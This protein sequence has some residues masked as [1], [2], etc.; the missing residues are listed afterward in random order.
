MLNIPTKV[1]LKRE[2]SCRHNSKD[3]SDCWICAE[4]SDE[5]LELFAPSL[6]FQYRTIEIKYNNAKST[7]YKASECLMT[8]VGILACLKVAIIWAM[9]MSASHPLDI[10]NNFDVRSEPVYKRF[11]HPA[12]THPA[13]KPRLFSHHTIWVHNHENVHCAAT[14]SASRDQST[15][16]TG[17][18]ETKIDK[19]M[20]VVEKTRVETTDMSN[21]IINENSVLDTN[22]DELQ[23]QSISPSITIETTR[24]KKRMWNVLQ[25][26]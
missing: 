23:H 26:H 6:N 25:T 12:L 2:G 1:T 24:K 10:N 14:C 20:S 11:K 8:A 7:G 19:I 18:L 9:Q 21:S 3:C 13:C 4:P 15:V 5:L 17:W 22:N 16:S